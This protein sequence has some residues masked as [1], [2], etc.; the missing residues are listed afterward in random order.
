MTQ[1][2]RPR[3][4]VRRLSAVYGIDVID[5]DSWMAG[6]PKVMPNDYIGQ[7]TQ[8]G[9]A[10][11]NQHR[12]DKPWS[13]LIVGSP[14][15]LA[16]GVC[17]PDQ[18]DGWERSFIKA[19]VDGVRPR[20]NW[21]MNEDNPAQIPIP[22]QVE[23]RWARDDKAG[24]PRWVPLD[25]RTPASLLEWPTPRPY[26]PPRPAKRWKPWQIKTG[27]WSTVWVLLTAGSWAGLAHADLTVSWQTQGLSAS[28]ASLLM[29]LWGMAGAPITRRQRR[30]VRR[31]IRA[32]WRRWWGT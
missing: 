20:L 23:Q 15:T 16:E 27:L 3:P 10:R 2:E 13:D 12:D 11:E 9:R 19:G 28:L 31:R 4:S 7:T 1:V 24:R 25:Q 18:L 26:A 8:K 6:R 22:R 17:T 32:R 5:H 14:R 29:C 30:A 21:I